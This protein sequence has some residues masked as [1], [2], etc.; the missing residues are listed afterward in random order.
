MNEQGPETAQPEAIQWPEGFAPQRCPVHVRNELAM[1]IP[2]ERV[3]AWLV[4]AA[5]WP[6]WY[7]NS[8]NVRFLEGQPPDLA[9]GT[10]FRWWTFGVTIESKVQE[11]VP[12][13][14]IAW[15][16]R[17]LGVL[18]YHAWLIWPT[19]EGCHVLTEESQHG[20]AARLGNLVRPT[21]MSHYHQLWLERLR[22]CAAGGFPP[23]P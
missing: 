16:A 22:N 6:S 14:R 18:A 12:G 7:P 19:A 15:D 4:R 1:P 20:W 13:E 3:W 8:K 11:L 2:A 5:L 17:G 10:S 9:L 21:R 23:R